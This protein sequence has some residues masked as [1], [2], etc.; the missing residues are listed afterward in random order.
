METEMSLYIIYFSSDV[1]CIPNAVYSSY[2]ALLKV[3]FFMRVQIY[4]RANG[5]LYYPAC[6]KVVYIYA[7]IYFGCA[8]MC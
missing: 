1:R 6:R 5:W 2:L 4:R 8:T 3:G 7:Y